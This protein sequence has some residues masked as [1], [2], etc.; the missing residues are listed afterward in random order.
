MYEV[1]LTVRALKF[2][3]K[4]DCTIRDRI[5]ERLKRLSDTP[6]PSDSKFITRIDGE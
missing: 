5:A 1:H 4:L 3:N 2:L 6:I